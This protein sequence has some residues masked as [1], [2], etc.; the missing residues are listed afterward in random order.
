MRGR[1]PDLILVAALAVLGAVV[2][3]SSFGGAVTRI[4]LGLPLALA[5]PGYALTA[6]LF[7]APTLGLAERLTL[8]LGTSL[9]MLAMV[10]L[11][12]NATPQGLTPATWAIA[13]ATVTLVA[14]LVAVRRRQAHAFESVRSPLGGL[15]AEQWSAF[16]LAALALTAALLIARSGALAPPGAGFTQLWMLRGTQPAANA[17]RIGVTNSERSTLTYRLDLESGSQVQNTWTFA[18]APGQSWQTTTSV[19]PIPAGA[20]T[21]AVLFRLDMPDQPYRQVALAGSR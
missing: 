14:A 8:T 6:A 15:P 7:P 17:V 10:G 18:L 16:G 1:H 2:V 4:A 11:A 21:A 20:P 3:L 13:L 5:L 19:N 12:L 9:A